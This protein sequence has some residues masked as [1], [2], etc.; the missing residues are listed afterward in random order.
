MT[1]IANQRIKMGGKY[2][3]PGD[4]IAPSEDDLADLPTGAVSLVGEAETSEAPELSDEERDAK[5]KA[6]VAE[7]ADADFKKDGNIRADSLKLLIEK[8]GFDVTADQVAEI[9]T[10]PGGG[11]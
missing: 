3:M 6:A 11:E 9:K 1:H 2:Y 5:L 8:V 10:A 4:P 7:L